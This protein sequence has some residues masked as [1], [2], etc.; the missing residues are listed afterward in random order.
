MCEPQ[1]LQ[2][3]IDIPYYNS[4]WGGFWWDT[5]G[6]IDPW[7]WLNGSVFSD[8]ADK[9]IGKLSIGA[10][11]PDL[12]NWHHL[13]FVSS[14]PID[15]SSWRYFMCFLKLDDSCSGEISFSLPSLAPFHD[16]N[17]VAYAGVETTIPMGHW[18]VLSFDLSNF[19]EWYVEDEFDKSEIYGFTISC[20]GD[21]WIDNP[22]F[23]NGTA[24][25]FARPTD[26]SSWRDVNVL[27][28][29]DEEFVNGT[30]ENPIGTMYAEDYARLQ[31]NRA[32]WFF[33]LEFGIDL[34]VRTTTL[35]DS[36]DDNCAEELFYEV[37]EDTGFESRGYF[38]GFQVDVMIALTGQT[39]LYAAGYADNETNALICLF[40]GMDSYLYDDNTVQ[41]EV[42][43]IF[44][45]PDGTEDALYQGNPC[46]VQTC[47]MT[48]GTTY[49]GTLYEDGKAFEI[50]NNFAVAF[51]TN[52]WYGYCWDVVNATKD[53]FH[54][55]CVGGC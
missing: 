41:H 32:N 37:L 35:W 15:G 22:I 6:F 45:A 42:S 48:Y 55:H 25:I 2:E 21:L 54:S 23:T 39:N 18:V 47:I 13:H 4:V 52:E 36:D 27:L 3:T 11:A 33:N 7:R 29:M 12:V 20:D 34:R 10:T 40:P 26:L 16:I 1:T 31:I 44:D 38:N 8:D 49:V 51:T 14:M 28:A 5:Y 46:Y 17:N 43:H 30:Y 53:K 19:T 50:N 24:S 9:V